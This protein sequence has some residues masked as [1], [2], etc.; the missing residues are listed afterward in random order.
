MAV[1]INQQS[2]IET[3][4][5]MPNSEIE[6]YIRA[7]YKRETNRRVLR[8]RII[9]GK[10]YREIIEKHYFCPVGEWQKE[11]AERVI[12]AKINEI[13]RME[14]KFYRVVRASR[15]K[16]DAR[17]V[18][19]GK[20]KN[21]VCQICFYDWSKVAPFASVPNFCPHCGADMRGGNK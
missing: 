10:T 8:E 13:Q 20:W 9:E 4:R 5:N 6:T 12:R 1:L 19:H 17:P 16:A 11:Q 18:V 14:T 15:R 21:G 7:A 3:V 2:E